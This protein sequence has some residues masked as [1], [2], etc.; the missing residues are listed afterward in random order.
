MRR[1]G[2]R[3]GLLGG[4]FNP[5]HGGHRRVSLFT[6]AALGL[7]EMWWLVSPGNPLKP[8]NGMA[9]LPARF[10]SAAAMARRA[11]I[12]VS[13]IEREFGS[14]Y[15]VDTLRAL[16]RRWPRH[17]FVWV[18][19]SDN[20]TQF[21]RWKDWRRIARTMPIAVIARPGY[22]A[23]AVA[24]PAMAWLRRY[25]VKAASFRNRDNW[26]APALIALRFDPDP[27]SATGIR[28]ADPQWASRFEGAACRDQLTHHLIDGH[29]GAER[30]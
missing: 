28:R 18:M 6:L 16:A 25:R 23:H 27:R 30:A 13:A 17:R 11:P 24:N 2:L 10:R 5:A 21:H 7:D 26:S 8:A 29:P 14:A 15:T 22:D 1:G 9:P 20:L 12:R 4:S 19:G 3:V